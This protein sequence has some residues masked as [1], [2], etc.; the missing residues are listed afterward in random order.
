MR[1]ANV[2][3]MGRPEAAHLDRHAFFTAW[4][5]R[6]IASPALRLVRP[7]ADAPRDPTQ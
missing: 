2:T 6:A 7:S 5:T 3:E 1:N 4:P